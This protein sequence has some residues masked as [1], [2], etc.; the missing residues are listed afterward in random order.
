MQKVNAPHA[1]ELRDAFERVLSTSAFS[2]GAEVAAF[3]ELL[4]AHTQTR[5][6]VAVN[7]G[8]AALMLALKAAGI[9]HNDEVIL[10][11]NTFFATAEAVMAIGATPVLVDC[12]ANTAL[13]NF[14]AA[15][16]AV[17]TRTKALIPVHLYGQPANMDRAR[18]I[19]AR[20]G[21]L[22][23]EDNA[24]AIG[25]KW[26]GMPTGSLGD[27]AGFSFYPGKNLGALG[28]GG[29]ITTN[30]A[31][32]AA[33]V[34]RLREHGSETK[35]AHDEWGYNERMHGMQAA[36]LSAKLP[37]LADA[38]QLRNEAVATY[39]E[40]LKTNL[41]VIWFETQPEVEHVYHLFVIRVQNRE[42]VIRHLS[43]AGIATGIHYPVPLHL[44]PA[45]QGKLGQ[46]GQFPIAEENAS[47]VLSLPLFAGITRDQIAYVVDQLAIAA[48]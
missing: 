27:A 5:F 25:A 13:I 23:L 16:A 43:E 31:Q 10:P 6:A 9:T 12:E 37:G 2:G 38:Q 48:E 46:P 17:S 41:R 19:A 36:F 29:A 30:D 21:L 40:L 15:E 11:A 44:T 7:S 4:A 8:T 3:E 28:E 39:R 22:L 1:R 34:R 26:K 47:S 33:S 14:D 32:I 20:N 24:Q 42:R 18:Q 35:Y 45:A